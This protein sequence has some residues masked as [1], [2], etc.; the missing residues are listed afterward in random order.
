[1]NEYTQE[2]KEDIKNRSQEANAR[3]KVVL[4]ELELSMK[5]LPIFVEV[6]NGQCST[7]AIVTYVDKKFSK[8]D[9]PTLETDEPKQEVETPAE[10][11]VV[12]DTLDA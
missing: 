6:I 5:A 9:E 4:D 3:V 1:M 10:G 12:A 2:Q 11:E 8:K 7:S